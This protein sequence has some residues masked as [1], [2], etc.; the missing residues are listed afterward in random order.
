MAP[1]RGDSEIGQRQRDT[2]RLYQVLVS[3]LVFA[4]FPVHVWLLTVLARGWYFLRRRC[5][6]RE[7]VDEQE[8]QDEEEMV[9]VPLRSILDAAT[10]NNRAGAGAQGEGKRGCAS[11]GNGGT[12]RKKQKQQT[13]PP[14]F[15][16]H[17][18]QGQQ[19]I[20]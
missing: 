7:Q 3:V 1:I 16:I 11:G 14:V 4:L 2:E 17:R 12:L 13:S 8:E 20:A 15:I 10:I 9:L 18:Q 5:H 19:L 6:Q